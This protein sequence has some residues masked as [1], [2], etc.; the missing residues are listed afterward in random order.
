MLGK[1]EGRRIK[2]W[3]RMRFSDGMTNSMDRSLIELQKIVKDREAWCVSV[4][5]V[6]KVWPWHSNWITTTCISRDIKVSL[7]KCLRNNYRKVHKEVISNEIFVQ[8]ILCGRMQKKKKKM[9]T[10]SSH[11]LV[12]PHLQ[13]DFFFPHPM[14]LW[15]LF[16]CL[17]NLGFI[18][19][20][21]L[22]NG[23]L[24]NLTQRED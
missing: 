11:F 13:C 16:L 19:W 20:L 24:T 14:K 7:K 10:S 23:T 2:G 5:G 9:A 3:Q 15:N 17:L 8:N 22:I 1:I 4:H 21:E 6:T 18:M 12:H